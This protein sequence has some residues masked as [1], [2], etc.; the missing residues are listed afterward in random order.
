M[1]TC[2]SN[3]R[4]DKFY[5][6]KLRQ[7]VR[8]TDT[9]KDGYITR[10]DFDL[11]MERY[12]Q[13]GV[14]TQQHLEKLNASLTNIL[15]LVGITDASVRLTYEQYEDKWFGVVMHLK[16][17]GMLEKLFL[18]MFDSTDLN[19]DGYLTFD[20]WTA[21]GECWGIEK[22]THR[23]SFDACDAN[24]DGKV[25]K[26]EFTNYGYEFI[27]STENKLNSSILYGPLE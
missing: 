22:G 8:V 17:K 1:A 25:S 20:E 27:A 16:E 11:V 18:S 2:V 21:H 15:D 26:E 7:F 3:L 14:C 10:H 19:G 4:E 12:K 24:G 6:R 13:L 5:A 23:A 9:D